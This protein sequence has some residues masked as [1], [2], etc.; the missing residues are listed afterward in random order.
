MSFHDFVHFWIYQTTRYI[1]PMPVAVEWVLVIL[2]AVVIAF[3]P[4]RGLEPLRDMFIG[5]ARRTKL[6]IAICGVLPL[7][8]RVALLGVMPVPDPS[9]HDEFAHLLLGDTLAHGRLSNRPHPLWQHFE[10]IHILQQP[11]YASMYL[12]GQGSFLALGQVLFHEPWAG[13]VISVGL[14]FAALCW[15]MQGWLPP[16]WA[17]YGTLIAI[18]RIGVTGP[19]MNSY[20][21]GPV[22]AIGGALLI[23]CVPRLRERRFSILNGVLFGTGVAILM[24]TRPY[25]GG[26]LTLTV[27]IYLGWQATS[28]P[29]WIGSNMIRRAA[30]PAAMLVACGA[31]FLGYYCRQVTGSPFRVP[32]QVN[33]ATYGWPENLA[34]LPVTKLK[35]RHKVMQDLYERELQHRDTYSRWDH[36]VDNLNTRLFDNWI[37][38]AGPALTIPLLFLPAIYRDRTTQMLLVFLGI[39]LGLNLF[40]WLLYPYHLAPSVPILLTILAAGMRQTYL[41]LLRRSPVRALRFAAVLPVVVMLVAGMKGSAETL[42]IPLSYWERSA[43]W[44]RDPRASLAQWLREQPGKQLVIVRYGARHNAD[45]EWVYNGADIDGSKVVWAREMTRAADA[46]LIRYFHDREIWL[47]QADVWPTRVV[48]YPKGGGDPGCVPVKAE[49]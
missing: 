7:I 36:A 8:A 47:L 2:G 41:W 4:I 40:Q 17:F 35:L 46:E 26:L 44:H 42:D 9:I 3:A 11:T 31:A 15:A 5:L 6:A 10:S 27:L 32:Y 34:F 14:M 24:N 43:E 38:F 39:M 12:P 13:V 19:W 48:L 45:Q 49:E 33:R 37:F 1:A 16:A 28:M 18:F 21:G 30:I 29:G 22:P 25:E 20:L 23:G